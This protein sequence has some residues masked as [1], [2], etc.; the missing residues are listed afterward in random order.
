M[1]AYLWPTCEGKIV[2]SEVRRSTLGIKASERSFYPHIRYQYEVGGSQYLGEKISFVYEGSGDRSII[3]NKVDQYPVGKIV[4]VHYNPNNPKEA[5]LEIGL[6]TSYIILL[7]AGFIFFG[8]GFVAY[9]YW[10][11][12]NA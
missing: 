12:L 7:I 6:K 5:V 10:D 8:V 9:K 3:Q 11:I 4:Q 2:V 1:V